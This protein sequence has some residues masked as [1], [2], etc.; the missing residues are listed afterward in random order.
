V[1][2]IS[3]RAGS[4]EGIPSARTK[5]HNENPFAGVKREKQQTTEERMDTK[6]RSKGEGRP[7][8]G[9]GNSHHDSP[10][11]STT[12]GKKGGVETEA[13]D[14]RWRRLKRPSTK[15]GGREKK[16][17]SWGPTSPADDSGV[18]FGG[19]GGSGSNEQLCSAAASRK[20]A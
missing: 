7:L 6:G 18:L 20:R 19:R 13:I 12:V 5:K 9:E 10:A 2:I 14:P 16:R 4:G 15:A 3:V 8:K 11:N 17:Q 1:Q